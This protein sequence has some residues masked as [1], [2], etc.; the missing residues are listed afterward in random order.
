M[1]LLGSAPDQPI[2]EEEKKKFER[3][4]FKKRTNM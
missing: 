2:L 3:R 4:I 1:G